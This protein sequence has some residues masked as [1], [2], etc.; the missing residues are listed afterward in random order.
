MG[1]IEEGD[2]KVLVVVLLAAQED[3]AGQELGLLT[4]H[5]VEG[6]GCWGT[7]VREKSGHEEG[8][9]KKDDLAG[10]QGF[11][12]RNRHKKDVEAQE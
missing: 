5:P 11:Q 4:G 12:E 6:R 3:G 10:D 8:V 1:H 7:Q 9:D 2:L